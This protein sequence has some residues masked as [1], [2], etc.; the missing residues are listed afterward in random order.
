M[1]RTLSEDV[2]SAVLKACDEGTSARQAA[3]R[4]GVGI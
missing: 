1:A 3:A 2:R 4:F